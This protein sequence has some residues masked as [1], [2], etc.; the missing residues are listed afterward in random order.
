MA[1]VQ[2]V[3]ISLTSYFKLL[4]IVLGTVFLWQIRDIVVILFVAFVLVQAL[5]PI[6]AWLTKRG[7]P[8]VLSVVFIYVTLISALV[9]VFALVLPPLIDQLRLLAAN[10]PY[11]ILK[12][13]PLYEALPATLNLQQF[14]TSVTDQLG[15]VTGNIVTLASQFFGG[16]V[17]V[18]TV[19]VIS[20]Y[21]LID[22]NQLDSLIHIAIPSQLTQEVRR[23]IEKIGRKVG[24]WVRGQVLINVI[25]GL[26]VWIGLSIIGLPYA[27]TLGVLAGILEIIPIIGP[28]VTEIIALIIALATGSW[29][30]ALAGL[31]V[32]TLLQQLEGQFI[33]PNV[34]KK[35]VGLSPV[36]IIVALLVGATVA[37]LPGAML[38]VPSAAVLDVLVDE[39]ANL[40]KA[41]DRGRV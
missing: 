13:R 31:V 9:A 19:F 33:V 30:L 23:V 32:F 38:A 34:M 4:L 7:W 24:G 35:A 37:G 12:I 3:E 15:N 41:F 27:L 22:E 39:W 28:I 5:N 1:E 8:R 40:R 26:S 21:L 6:V 14:L 16:V 17:A 20:F 18:V 36:V 25:M 2:K 10:V 11:L 29:G